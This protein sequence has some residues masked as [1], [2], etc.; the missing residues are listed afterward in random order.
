MS[1]LNKFRDGLSK[2]RQFVTEGFNRVAANF[3]IFDEDF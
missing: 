3:G 1:L 2:T